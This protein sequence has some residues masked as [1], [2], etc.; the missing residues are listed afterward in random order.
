MR[1]LHI[2][3]HYGTAND[4]KYFL[5][6]L[7]YNVTT[8]FTTSWPYKVTKQVAEEKWEQHKVEFQSYDLI[9]TSDTVA[10]SYP[11]LLNLHE[12]KPKLV[13]WICNRFNIMVETEHHFIDLFRQNVDNSV[14]K[15]T[16]VPYTAYEVE[17]CKRY[18]IHLKNSVI[19]PLGR[20][21]E[22][23]MCEEHIINQ[24]FKPLDTS[25]MH[26]PKSETFYIQDYSNNRR[27]YNLVV[28][29]GYSVVFGR[30]MDVRELYEYKAVLSY[31]DA[32][33]KIFT[34]EAIQ[35]AIPV[36]LP[37]LS[38]LQE[39]IKIHDYNFTSKQY[40]TDDMLT[41]CEYLNNSSCHI[42][43]DSTEDMFSKM[44]SFNKEE[45]VQQQL[46]PKK[47]EIH[48]ATI[49]KWRAVLGKV[50]KKQG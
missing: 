33:C 22:P 13:I 14:E 41:M 19:P 16:I 5:T 15:V 3:Y 26:K 1:A 43:Y 39:L 23:Y 12:L 24:C 21:E 4:V 42:L 10:L 32:F 8:M 6:K 28:S 31:P 48:D 27:L 50:A 40:I 25:H 20:H 45:F 18:N 9:F 44:D 17:W 36:F 38:F 7:G 35:H 47:D 2:T 46:L 29:R 30:Y 49:E 37:S 11:F 34:L